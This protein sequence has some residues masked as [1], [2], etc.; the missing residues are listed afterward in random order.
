MT[1][2]KRPTG[3]VVGWSVLENELGSGEHPSHGEHCRA[4]AMMR[5]M[6]R[7]SLRVEP[8]GVGG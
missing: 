4:S 1:I 8:A 5:D 2:V 7:I 6:G 3:H